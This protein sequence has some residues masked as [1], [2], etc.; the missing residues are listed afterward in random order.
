M[1]LS[2]LYTKPYEIADYE[3]FDTSY[4]LAD[5]YCALPKFSAS[6]DSA[7]RNSPDFVES[8]ESNSKLLLVAAKKLRHPTLFRECLVYEVA[9]LNYNEDHFD[10][11]ARFPDKDLQCVVLAVRNNL[12]DVKSLVDLDIHA[13]CPTIKRD[14]FDSP[15]YLDMHRIYTDY[16]FPT[17]NCAWMYRR[18]LT[19]L[20]EGPNFTVIKEDSSLLSLLSCNLSYNAKRTMRVGEKVG[21]LEGFHEDEDDERFYCAEIADEHL[22]WDKDE[23]DW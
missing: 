3:E 4:R 18:I 9:R 2:A 10:I 22:P 21:F 8:I 23:I 20:I 16:G 11:V 12:Q 1:L 15:E 14:I 7:I 6:L 13:L 5:F 19:R 17:T